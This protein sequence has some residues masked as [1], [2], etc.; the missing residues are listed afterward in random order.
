M[1]L[2]KQLW[3]A[4]MLLV[5]V[6]FGGSVASSIASSRNYLVE[7]LEEKNIDN[8]TALALTMS[9]MDK[10]MVNLE[11][12]LSAQFD[13]GHYQLIRLSDSNGNVMLERQKEPEREPG[14]PDWFVRLLALDAQ[15]GFALVQDGWSQFGRIRVE[16]DARFAYGDLWRGSQQMLFISLL[17]GLLCALVGTVLLR[18]I[19]SPLQS[20]VQQAEA[21]GERRFITIEEP[22]TAEFK[23]VVGAMNRL[24]GRIRKMLEEES[25]RLEQLRQ[26]ANFDG[27]S[28]LMKRD[29]FFSRI[30]TLRQED[31]FTEGVLAVVRLRDLATID[32][33]LGH[34]ETDALLHR[35]G[36]ALQTLTK[37]N[38][39]L[40]AGR[41]SGTDFAV[42]SS[43]S[44]D[45][46]NLAATVKGL[47]AKAGSQP[48][49][50]FRLP[51]VCGRFG[52]TDDI[53]EFYA[54][55]DKMLLQ[56]A[57]NS[58][59][60]LQVLRQDTPAG[61]QEQDETRWR[62]LLTEAID[63]GRLKLAQ[64]P[65]TAAD[66]RI[67]H[68]ESPARMQLGDSDAWLPAGEF[69]AWANRLD[70]VA[71]IDVLV[72]EQALQALGNEGCNDIGLNISSRAMCDADFIA[73]VCRRIAARPE[74]AH[75]LWLEVPERGAF[76]HLAEFRNFCARL[77]PLG[78][79]IGI[80]HVGAYVARL[81]E[82]H[83][84]GLDYIK[85]DV[86]VISGIVHNA[87]NQAFL[88]GLCL[89]AHSI[90]LMT[91]AEGLQSD[92]EIT[93]LPGLGVD[94]MTGP[95]VR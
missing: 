86:S 11:L 80:E 51:A 16:S 47:L 66:G 15:P 69:I 18:R 44:T 35:L 85:I 95:A 72:V 90:G 75:R 3:I 46:F 21:I 43:V 32:Q 87:G 65:V 56:A 67:I 55:I 1:S 59:D 91:I 20:V 63:A 33:T 22:K 6:I 41:V 68:L 71:R 52:K 30:D 78:C 5:V 36:N 23:L 73:H 27:P 12:L 24:T 82:L 19:L 49:A 4:I 57:Q 83:D 37:K 29:Y 50:D 89:I 88:R 45:G 64:Y 61:Q 38:K 13:A 2:I 17:I 9:Q 70:L 54:A 94:G 81:G 58:P 39:H 25:Q 92:D 26:D 31:D 14:V 93:L 28:R 7:Q 77:K 60:A 42:F 84:L 76:E 8:A 40:M 48:P 10:D 62:G 79:K 74:C 34:Q 53:T